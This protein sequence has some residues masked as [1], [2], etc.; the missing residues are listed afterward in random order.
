MNC[1]GVS[2]VERCENDKYEN[3]RNR[4]EWLLVKKRKQYFEDRK[5]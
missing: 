1:G 5:E 2:E 3:V 4:K